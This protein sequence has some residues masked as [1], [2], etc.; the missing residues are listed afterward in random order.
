MYCILQ[1]H[2]VTWV[3]FSGSEDNTEFTWKQPEFRN[4]DK[5]EKYNLTLLMCNYQPA[6]EVEAATAPTTTMR[7]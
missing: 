7:T 4:E 3:C 2:K 5:H 1:Q 6:E